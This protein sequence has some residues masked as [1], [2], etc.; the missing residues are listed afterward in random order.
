[1]AEVSLVKV[2]LAL[3]CGIALAAVLGFG[4]GRHARKTDGR[5]L[6]RPLFLALVCVYALGFAAR[7]VLVEILP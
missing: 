3:G 6:F 2:A 5:D 1:M 4:L 7:Y